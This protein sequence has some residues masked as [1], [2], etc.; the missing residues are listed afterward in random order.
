MKKF[1]AGKRSRFVHIL[2]LLL[3]MAVFVGADTFTS[4][5]DDKWTINGVSLPLDESGYRVGDYIGGGKCWQF[6]SHIYYKIWN[7]VFYQDPGSDDD[8]LRH[9]PHGNARRI[10]AENAKLLISHAPV[11]AVIRLQTIESG[12]DSTKTQSRHSLI[13]LDKTEDGCTLYHLWSGTATISTLTW[14]EFE[15]E[16]RTNIDFGYFK[17]IKYPGAEALDFVYDGDEMEKELV[18][19]SKMYGATEIVESKR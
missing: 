12:P 6:A 10:T 7:R 5:A 3:M 2:L 17:Y 19:S 4:R 14:A 15:Q 13:L 11:G 9:Y 18:I 8:M 16:Y 1:I